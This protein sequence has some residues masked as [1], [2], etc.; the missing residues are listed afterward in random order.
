MYRFAIVSLIIVFAFIGCKGPKNIPYNDAKFALEL[1]SRTITPGTARDVCVSGD[2]MFVADNERGVTIWDVSN[3]AAPQWIDTIQTPN[4]AVGVAYAPLSKL[5]LIDVNASSAMIYNMDG[6]R[7]V[8]SK[9][10][11]GLS[12][13]CVDEY[14]AYTVIIAEVDGGTGGA[15]GEGYRFF[16]L[17]KFGAQWMDDLGGVYAPPLGNFQGLA[18]KRDTTYI[19]YGEFGM[20][21]LRVDYSTDGN[22]PVALIGETDTPGSALDIAL[23]RRKTHALIAGNSGGLQ[24]V[25]VTMPSNP[26]I[27]AS[28]LLEGYDE[29]IKIFAVG[30]T[31]YLVEKYT[32]I[33]A[34][35][36][37]VP[38][39]P[40]L[41]ALY[42]TPR[43]SNIFITPNHL[44]YLA[45]EFIGL[46]ILRWR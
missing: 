8:F 46:L 2:R 5:L 3:P 38:S 39:Q 19:A 45:D 34:V 27:T 12:D 6:K 29:T 20:Q 7:Y 11:S 24:I 9:W 23:N 36:V 41:I 26:R 44:I 31:A 15:R 25:D 37:S 33:Y 16:R 35:D 13:M 40:R 28:L 32:G 14:S 30:D 42:N 22:F 43:P 10:D 1:V 18:L 4:R 17:Y 21:V